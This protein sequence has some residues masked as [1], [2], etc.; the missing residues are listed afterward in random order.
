MTALWIVIGALILIV[1]VLWIV[2][3]YLFQKFF[4]RDKDMEKAEATFYDIISKGTNADKVPRL[5]EGRRWLKKQPYEDVYIDSYDGLQLHGKLYLNPDGGSDTI[6][7]VHGYKSTPEQDFSCGCPYYFSQG[8]NI[9]LI[10]QRAHGASQGK[11]ICFGVKERYDVVAWA[12]WMVHR[13]GPGKKY[14]MGGMSM[15]CTTVLLAAALPELPSEIR[16][17]VADC[18]FTSA[19]QE[20]GHVLKKS[21]NI[22]P[23]PLLN[24]MAHKCRCRAGFN[25]REISTQEAAKDIKIPVLFI[26]GEADNFV[27]PEFSKCNYAA[28]GAENKK[29][30]LVPGADHG[31][32]FLVDE[33]GYTKELG[34]FIASL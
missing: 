29:L 17:V 31:M 12:K 23:F 19:Y 32:S 33:P 18:G 13:F 11:Y 8:L 21:H 20:F 6:L 24:V 22:P 34:E 30:L 16:G 28:C 3:E 25:F 15:G 4:T 26:H 7:L 14:L 5:K 2:G 1:I 10:D 27:L 9:L